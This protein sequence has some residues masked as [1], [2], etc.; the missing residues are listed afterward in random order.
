MILLVKFIV[1]I[2]CSFLVCMWNP[3]RL[4][5]W[6]AAPSFRKKCILAFIVSR[7]GVFVMIFFVLKLPAQSDINWYY[8]EG[9]AVISGLLPL[10]DFLPVYGPWFSVICAW[11]LSVVDS[12]V[13]LV[14][15]A[16]ILEI[17][18]IPCWLRVGDRLFSRKQ[19][20]AGLLLYACC[21][22][23]L[24]NVPVT[25]QNHIW[26]AP[27]LACAILLLT[28]HRSLLCG[29]MMAFTILS[30][31]FLSMLFV[32]PFCWASKRRGMFILGFFGLLIPSYGWYWWQGA[33]LSKLMSFHAQ[34]GSS[35]NLPFLLGITGLD[36]SEPGLRS[37]ANLTGLVLL[38]GIFLAAMWQRRVLTPRQVL[39]FMPLLTLV[40]LFISKKSYASYLEMALFPLCLLIAGASK[41]STRII[42]AVGCAIAACEPSV[43]FRLLGNHEL[44]SLWHDE[45]H[46]SPVWAFWLLAAMDM[47]LLA[48][49]SVGIGWLWRI[50]AA[51]VSTQGDTNS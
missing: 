30:V 49:Y 8:K 34:H 33:D 45:F 4:D 44:S 18:S 35:G 11:L 24:L 23:S 28:W 21:P 5:N 6:V 42:F 50:S 9:R 43:W 15:F 25:G 19:S 22:L 38:S 36:F 1:A 39:I 2:L 41:N 31:K 13:F 29:M 16:V 48:F 14:F 17:V 51:E 32:P 27:L 10:R 7:L 26:Y 37:M 20:N 46:G 3:L 12:P 40:T 47:A